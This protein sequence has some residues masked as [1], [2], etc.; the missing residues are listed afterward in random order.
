M[1]SILWMVIIIIVY[2]SLFPFNFQWVEVSQVQWLDWGSQVKHRTTNGDILSN[3]LTFV[4]LGYFGV[5]GPRFLGEKTSIKAMLVCIIGGVFAFVLQLAQFFLPSRVPTS[6]DALVNFLGI[7][8]GVGIALFIQYWLKRNPQQALKWPSDFAVPLAM[9][10]T[11]VL[12]QLFPYIPS[13]NLQDLLKGIQGLWQ[14]P[15]LVW[16]EWLFLTVMWYW[17]LVFI[18]H[19]NLPQ[20]ISRNAHWIIVSVV[21]GKV[22]IAHNSIDLTFLISII[23]GQ[24]AFARFKLVYWKIPSLVILTL[25]VVLREML[26]LD[27][28]AESSHFNWIPFNYYLSGS[29]WVNTHV[30]LEKLFVYG[31]LIYGFNEYFTK[32]S[33]VSKFHGPYIAC[34]I[35]L[36]IEVLQLVTRYHS[37]DA[38]DV[39]I[40]GIIGY[41]FYQL[42][43]VNQI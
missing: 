32:R 19:H 31:C 14:T 7:G 22:L 21:L 35:I 20:S 10:T 30:V 1:L 40:V 9:L 13:F 43:R 3:F 18:N 15:L 42:K 11:W 16:Q 5:A 23:S 37:A 28:Q 29:M 27:Q 34:G 36:L 33:P 6:G 4:P 24:I 8:T 25:V 2:G 38:T 17:F 41:T 26:P 12:Y 39:I